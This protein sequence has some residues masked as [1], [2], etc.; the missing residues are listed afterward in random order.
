MMF[1]G[2]SRLLGFILCIG[3]ITIQH[4]V[5][6][7]HGLAS[8]DIIFMGSE[9]VLHHQARFLKDVTMSTKKMKKKKKQPSPEG[10]N[11]GFD[12]N[13]SSKRRFRRG[14]DPIHNRSL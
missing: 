7:V 1:V 6:V 11:K 3:L 4:H 2:S 8:K 14:S 9:V 13:Q 12:P 5:H 10:S